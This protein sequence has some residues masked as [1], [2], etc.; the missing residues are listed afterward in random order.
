MDKRNLRKKKI[1]FNRKVLIYYSNFKLSLIITAII[2]AYLLL[3]TNLFENLKKD[4]QTKFYNITAKVGLVLENLEIGDLKNVT[5]QEI[6]ECLNADKGIPIFSIDLA[7]VKKRLEENTWVES[8]IIAR[9][10]P[11]TIA[12]QVKERTPI[13]I[14]QFE[15][16]LYLIDSEGNRIDTYHGQKFENLIQVVGIDAN[17]YAQNLLNELNKYP[18][19]AARVKSAVR[20]G[21][22]RWNLNFNDNFTV[23]MPEKDFS[24]AYQYLADLNKNAKLFGNNYK[25]LDLRDV[26]K[27]YLEQ[28]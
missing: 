13:A 14:W 1:S 22:R 4:I 11:S 3:F 27:Y 12:I 6:V 10:F 2:F 21:Q 25:T 24:R 19:L 17:I 18:A 23:K 26:E 7:N 9:K 16:R 28:H 8:V 15:G 20:Y 5:A